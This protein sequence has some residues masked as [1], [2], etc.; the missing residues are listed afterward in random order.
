MEMIM[1]LRN[2]LLLAVTMGLG[3]ALYCGGCQTPK[4]VSGECQAQISNCLQR[5]D[6]SPTGTVNDPFVQTGR[7][8]NFQ[9]ACEND[10]HKICH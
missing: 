6:G 8:A 9:K 7:P 5:C 3:V 4:P 2:G 10:C 1:K